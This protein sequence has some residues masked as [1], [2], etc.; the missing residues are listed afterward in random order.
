MNKHA[1]GV[2]K[3]L[4]ES[5]A[6]APPHLRKGAVL[7]LVGA[8]AVVAGVSGFKSISYQR[9][10]NAREAEFSAGP[11]I[12]TAKVKRGLGEHRV[13]L[14]GETRPFQSATL[15]AKVSGYLK[16]I[17]V[18]KGDAV[19]GGQVLA[20]IQSPETDQAFVAA[21]ADSKNKQAILART[22]SLYDKQLVSQQEYDQAR[23]DADVATAKLSSQKTLKD[24]EVVRAPFAGTIT[25]RY[26]DPGALVQNATSS[27]T[28][29]LPVVMISEIERL[30]VDL[31]VDQR[32]A[33]YVKEGDPVTITMTE[34]PD[35]KMEG[36]VAR[37]TGQLDPR[38]KMLLTEID[39]SNK[40][41][42][43]IAGSFV[44]V[45]MMIKSPPYLKAPVE[46]LAL[47]DN[48]TY[49]TVMKTDDTLTFKE[50]N[51]ASN[52]GKTLSILSGA[53]DGDTV[54]LN[55]GTSLQE[56]SKVRPTEESS[57]PGD[58]K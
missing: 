47:K 11:K 22:K 17:V 2:A 30:K 46:A 28:S 45:S 51:I 14:I 6:A 57:G 38:T 42:P 27:E 4:K 39:I 13:T 53:D 29:A 41:H 3:S 25:A 43:L 52:D 10:K 18:D 36:R 9:E 1:A 58:K 50:I 49:L 32:D 35:F 48:K 54:A 33:S 5:V 44:Q 26:A 34:R 21:D 16:K 19:E 12:R 8:F 40:N 7:L 55:V 20:V 23:T 31:F 56:G 15:Y 37:V 24:Y